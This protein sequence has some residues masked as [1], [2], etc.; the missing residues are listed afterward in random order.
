[1]L[2]LSRKLGETIVIG[3]NVSVTVLGVQGGRV[4]LGFD[5][6]LEASIHRAEVSKRIAGRQPKLRLADCV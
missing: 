5:A 3:E 6:P 1:M 4:R 2:V